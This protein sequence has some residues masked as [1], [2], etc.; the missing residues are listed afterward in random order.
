MNQHRQ[1]AGSGRRGGV[2][3]ISEIA[4]AMID[5]VLAKRAGINTV[6]LGAWDEIAGAD[7]ADCTRP[8]RIRWDRRRREIDP[9]EGGG[10]P[11]VLT[12]ACESA[13]ALYLAHAT[14]DLIRRVNVFFGFPAIDRVRIVQKPVSAAPG[15]ALRRARV[16]PLAEREKV[17]LD[18]MLEGVEDD[19]LRASLERLGRGVIGERGTGD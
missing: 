16:R 7:F 3:Q 2:R 17:R 9:G 6:L 5:P 14:D 12:V 1:R 4:N 10:E 11:G 19:G 13:R 8:E 15:A 18:A